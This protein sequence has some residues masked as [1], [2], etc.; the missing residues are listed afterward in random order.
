MDS[1][2]SPMSS[3]NFFRELTG[4]YVRGDGGG[5]GGEL[6]RG[7][8]IFS[9]LRV[10][11]TSYS[12]TVF[13]TLFLT[14][15][16]PLNTRCHNAYPNVLSFLVVILWLDIGIPPPTSP[17]SLINRMRLLWTLNKMFLL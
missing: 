14:T 16:E 6:S 15:V 7:V 13:V 17:Q 11:L 2:L 10:V 1:T 5:E 9:L 8:G 12:G 3:M 4:L